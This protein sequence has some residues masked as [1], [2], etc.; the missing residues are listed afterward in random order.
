MVVCFLAKKI[1]NF[2]CIMLGLGIGTPNMK[3]KIKYYGYCVLLRETRIIKSINYS[4]K[5]RFL[6][7]TRSTAAPW[8]YLS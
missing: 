5:G 2:V 1:I 3:P 4:M 8:T 7:Y 6:V